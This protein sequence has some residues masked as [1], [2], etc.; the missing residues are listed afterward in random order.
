MKLVF[1]YIDRDGSTEVFDPINYKLS[2]KKPIG[3]TSGSGVLNA[4]GLRELN[5]SFAAFLNSYNKI[6]G[7]TGDDEL[8]RKLPRQDLIDT[9]LEVIST[10]IGVDVATPHELQ[11]VIQKKI[12]NVEVAAQSGEADLSSGIE[13]FTFMK[14]VHGPNTSQDQIKDSKVQSIVDASHRRTARFSALDG[15]RDALVSGGTEVLEG[16]SAPTDITGSEDGTE[17]IVDDLKDENF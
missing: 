4:E 7:K 3:L 15:S 14:P 16:S 2:F 17:T 9:V 1:N 12:E 13:P 8:R 11:K 5:N 10:A 6:I